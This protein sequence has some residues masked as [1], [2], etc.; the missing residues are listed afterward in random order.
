MTG[1][2]G[3]SSLLKNSYYCERLQSTPASFST[4]DDLTVTFSHCFGH[5]GS[6]ASPAMTSLVLATIGFFNRLLGL[7]FLPSWFC[8]AFISD[9][10]EG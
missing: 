1:S 2:C 7:H 10:K 5:L 3:P 9:K 6:R 4:L 8:A